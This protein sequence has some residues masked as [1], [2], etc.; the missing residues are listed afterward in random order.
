MQQNEG[1]KTSGFWGDPRT[2]RK[3]WLQITSEA[4]KPCKP[5]AMITMIMDAIANSDVRTVAQA[6]LMMKQLLDAN[7]E[8]R[9]LFGAK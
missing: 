9:R 4:A 5:S 6:N 1:C 8:N 2:R 3:Q 7:K